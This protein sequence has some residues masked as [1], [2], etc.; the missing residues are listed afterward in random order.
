MA[1][2][3]RADGQDSPLGA[4]EVGVDRPPKPLAAAAFSAVIPG[5]GQWYAGRRSR[6][7]AFL[8]PFAVGLAV[9][10][11]TFTVGRRELLELAVQPRFLWGLLGAN[12]LFLVLRVVAVADGYLIARNPNVSESAWVLAGSLPAL[13]VLVAAPHLF[14]ASYN[15]QAIDLLTTVFV[16]DSQSAAPPVRLDPPPEPFEPAIPPPTTTVANYVSPQQHRVEEGIPELSLSSPPSTLAVATGGIPDYTLDSPP[17]PA[18]PDTS[19]GTVTILLAGGDAGPGRRGLRT[20]SIMV[21][22]LDTVANRAVI[23]GIPRNLAQVPLPRRWDDLFDE[24]CDCF[25]E[26]INAL[27]PWTR[28]HTRLFPGE[29]DPG[30]AALRGAMEQLLSIRI[31]YYALVDMQGFVDVV[32]AMGGVRMYVNRRVHVRL[33]PAEEGDE[34]EDYE[35]NWGWQRL[36]GDEALAYTRSR[37]QS[38]DYDRMLRQRCMLGAVAA[39]ADPLTVLRSFP[40]LA[41]AMKYSVTTDIPLSLL[42]QLMELTAHL[43]DLDIAT[44]GFTPPDYV[45]GRDTLNHPL[46]DLDK[47]RST[48]LRML[49]GDWETTNQPEESECS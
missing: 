7:L 35:I 9:T 43:E 44:V 46:P 29:V 26:Q 22:S 24:E 11:G 6:A 23:F 47:I 10:G 49:A 18:G 39:Q 15:L 12:V 31:D 4:P 41:D 2:R 21:A 5:M 1:V 27:Y 8:V 40:R 14:A 34:W 38:S 48:V 20:D 25:P 37:T 17:E 3:S 28:T 32:D 13:G 33:S 16:A 42:P 30:M 45:S 19:L 36:N